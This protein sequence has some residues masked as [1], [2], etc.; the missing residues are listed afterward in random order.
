MI[1]SPAIVQILEKHRSAKLGGV[2][3]R[4]SKI[5]DDI[6]KEVKSKD[7][8]N[9]EDVFHNLELSFKD[10]ACSY[11]D[12]IFD[13]IKI[14]FVKLKD[15]YLLNPC[16]FCGKD[17]YISEREATQFLPEDPVGTLKIAQVKCSC[18]SFGPRKFGYAA[19]QEAVDAWNT[20]QTSFC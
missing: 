8:W 1:Q 16:P 9:V 10:Y 4:T 20:Q 15:G 5:L 2:Y 14:D 7:E 3:G 18:G 19:V 11:T 17:P 13:K 12:L 6:C